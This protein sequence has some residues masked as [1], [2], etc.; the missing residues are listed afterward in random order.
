MQQ[1]ALDP[2]DSYCSPQKQ[3]P[4]LASTLPFH[5]GGVELIKL[6]VPVEQLIELPFSGELKRLKSN[7]PSDNLQS[8][9]DMSK[10]IR[11]SFEAMRGEYSRLP[12]AS[13]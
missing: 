1:S 7:V 4:L 11:Q 2:L 3:F 13:P 8:L 9:E 6:G 10:K 5:D 12:E